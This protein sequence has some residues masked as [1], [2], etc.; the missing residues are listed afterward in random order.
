MRISTAAVQQSAL[1]DLMRA[2]RDLA[3]SGAQ[4][5]SGKKGPDFKTYGFQAETITATRAAKARAESYASSLSRLEDRLAVQ[6][7]ALEE[8]S[9]V[10]TELR[11]TL[12]TTD[13][14]FMLNDVQALFERAKQALNTRSAN[15]GFVF[16]GTRSDA[17]PFTADTLAD[18]TAAPSAASLFENSSRIPSVRTDDATTLEIGFL[19]DD[20]GA[21]LMESIR[22]V[23]L[24]DAGPNGPFAGQV[25]PAQQTFLQNEIQNVITAFDRINERQAE[26]GALQKSIETRVRGYELEADFFE[27]VIADIEEVDVAEAATRFQQA[28]TAV[29]VS[30]Q[31]FAILSETSIL[32]FLR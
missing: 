32:P 14:T 19:A 16:G 26:N 22:Q 3:E 25:S 15:G 17:E 27:T 23:A 12:T 29:Q 1:M 9:D 6:D 31:T 18:L 5:S 13:G 11:T 10:A 4:V 28:Q 2:Q 8:L 7:I 20:V 30:A 21:Q 24:F